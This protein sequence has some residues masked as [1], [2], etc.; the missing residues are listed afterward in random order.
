MVLSKFATPS[1]D[2]QASTKKRSAASGSPSASSPG[3]TKVTWAMV[4]KG[5][6]KFDKQCAQDS[7][8]SKLPQVFATVCMEVLASPAKLLPTLRAVQGDDMRRGP[9][10]KKPKSSKAVDDDVD[11]LSADME[12]LIQLPKYWVWEV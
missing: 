3:G 6:T 8:T 11:E 9:V 7:S 5:K 10:L 4:V 12:K 2:K 1:K